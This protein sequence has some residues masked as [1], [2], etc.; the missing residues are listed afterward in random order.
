[1]R[2]D[3]VI[4]A[5]FSFK[6]AKSYKCRYLYHNGNHYVDR[7]VVHKNA[8]NMP[9]SKYKSKYKLHDV[10]IAELSR[11][12]ND[13]YRLV[14]DNQ[15]W[16]TRI[17]IDTLNAI[18]RYLKHEWGVD[19]GVSYH[20]KYRKLGNVVGTYIEFAGMTYLTGRVELFFRPGV[21]RPVIV[22]LDTSTKIYFFKDH[23]ELRSIYRLYR[24]FVKLYDEVIEMFKKYE[25]DIDP[26][27]RKTI[28]DMF[29]KMYGETLPIH[30]YV[31]D[32]LVTTYNTVAI[33]WGFDYF[34]VFAQYVDDDHAKFAKNLIKSEIAYAKY[35]MDKLRR[36]L[37]IAELIR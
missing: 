26:S 23:P 32:R 25:R 37:A 21:A 28:N 35:V 2:R 17:T 31:I 33:N 20:L 12:S 16:S 8:D 27:T 6:D 30:D 7:V 3:R 1:M 15:G 34:G 13:L 29:K 4:E 18:L 14:L 22:V 24:R 36:L 10:E 11:F 5:F 9:E 19:H